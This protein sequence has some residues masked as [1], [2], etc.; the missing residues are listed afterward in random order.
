MYS[1]CHTD[2]YSHTPLVLIDVTNYIIYN[3]LL[4][5]DL[6]DSKH[7][8]QTVTVDHNGK[9]PLFCHEAKTGS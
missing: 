8:Q 5:F 4:T 9:L 3:Y 6:T 7:I 1:G 2:S